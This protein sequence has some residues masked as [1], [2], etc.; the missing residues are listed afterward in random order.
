MVP[1]FD[2]KCADT[3]PDRWNRNTKTLR[4]YFPDTPPL[5]LPSGHRFPAQKYHLLAG[6]I[7][8]QAILAP[9]ELVPSP[10]ATQAMLAVAHDAAYIEAMFEG[11]LP[12]AIEARIG[13]PWSPVLLARALATVGGTLAA[14][15]YALA[16]RLS[17]QL[18]GG[19]HHAHRDGGAGFCVF[20]D[21][22]V[23]SLNLLHEGAITRAAILDLDVHH[24]DGNATILATE[25]RVFVASVH[26]ANN[27]PFV[28]PA[29]DLDIAL[30]DGTAD[31]DYLAACHDA[32]DAVLATRPQLVF[33][34]AGVDPLISDRLGR[35]SVTHAGLMAR[36][37]LVMTA[38]REARIALVVLIGGGYGEPIGDTVEAYLN[39]WRV[40]AEIYR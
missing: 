31:D 37:R 10:L 34:I 22:A 20:N 7:V 3:G 21:C 8:E 33:Y 27:Y 5:P 29:S 38:C 36:D 32:L 28:K 39:T 13:L 25:S 23:A 6:S 9:A 30:A 19:T 1:T 15:R 12:K 14:A 35:L 24:G 16:H 4:V 11:R 40:A 17:G 26:G 2:L 18:A